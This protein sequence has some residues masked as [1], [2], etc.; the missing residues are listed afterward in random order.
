M[1]KARCLPAEGFNHHVCQVIDVAA[2]GGIRDR[3]LRA[4]GIGVVSC[5]GLGMSRMGSG[6]GASIP[7][8]ASLAAR[9][10]NSTARGS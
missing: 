1:R 6:Q 3:F 9:A 2:R 10:A 7:L 5:G 4:E 8:Q